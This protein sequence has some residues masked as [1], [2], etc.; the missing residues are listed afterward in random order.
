MSIVR[1]IAAFFLF[2]FLQ[3]FLFNKLS[4]IMNDRIHLIV[5]FLL[6]LPFAMNPALLMI[7]AF[8][9]GFAVDLL[10]HNLFYGVHSFA[11]VLMVWLRRPWVSLFTN[12]V[13]FRNP[14]DFDIRGQTLSWVFYYLLFLIFVHEFTYY[15]LDKFSFAQ[16]HITLF[17]T[18]M[19]TLL[20]LFVSYL[21]FF[22]FYRTRK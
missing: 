5:V 12:R 4:L 1:H 10:S 16:F 7:T 6:M 11:A 20:T 14:E 21:V 18:V 19:G 8:F 2:V 17:K 3:V 22:L 13:T 9:T 15:M